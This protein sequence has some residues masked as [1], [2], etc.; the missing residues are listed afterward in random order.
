MALGFAFM[1]EWITEEGDDAVVQP[2]KDV[3]V[4]AG[5]RYCTS[6]FINPDDVLQHFRI[7]SRGQLGESHH[8]AEHDGKLAAFAFYL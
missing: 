7:D 3:A 1:R 4:V 5:D 6:V 8:V 2:L